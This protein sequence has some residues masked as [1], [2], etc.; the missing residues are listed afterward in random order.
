MRVPEPYRALA[1]L[2][3]DAGWK[4]T[5]C[6]SGHLRWAPPRGRP[7]FTPSSPGDVRGFYEVRAKLR[8]AGLDDR[9]VA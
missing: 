4:I 7:V 2:A 3:H 5:R 9:K 1:R 6:G 8:R